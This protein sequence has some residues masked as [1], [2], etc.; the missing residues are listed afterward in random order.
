MDQMQEVF[1]EVMSSYSRA[2]AIKDGAL[3]DISI[4]A[5]EAGFKWPV[6]V[7]PGVLEI[8][9]PWSYYDGEGKMDDSKPKPGRPLY[10]LGQSFNGR[11]WDM[12]MVM[13]HAI[14]QGQRGTRVDFAP[15]F[16]MPDGR[17]DR[18]VPVEM[19]SVCGPGDTPEPVITIMM[20]EED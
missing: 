3:I 2:Q 6:A 14:R 17:P 10:G 9:A 15:L 8:L 12:L 16:L 13:L 1:G 18:P 20:P 7:T 4:L 19:Y 11:A 5:R